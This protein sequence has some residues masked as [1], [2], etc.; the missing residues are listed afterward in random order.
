MLIGASTLAGPGRCIGCGWMA[1]GHH[2]GAGLNA[3][4]AQYHADFREAAG[5]MH[6]EL[7]PDHAMRC[8]QLPVCGGLYQAMQRCTLPPTMP[9][10]AEMHLT[11]RH[12]MP[13]RES[14]FLTGSGSRNPTSTASIRL[15]RSPSP[16]SRLSSR[17]QVS[18]QRV[19]AVPQSPEQSATLLH[20]EV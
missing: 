8:G 18:P 16:S 10:H 11:L 19:S 15:A 5:N 6:S 13:C 2:S 7:F 1:W 17:Q 20:T 12:A 4:W 14:I 3:T 9:C